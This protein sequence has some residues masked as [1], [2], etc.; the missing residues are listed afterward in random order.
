MTGQVVG[1]DVAKA[2]FD[3]STQKPDGKRKDLG[4]VPNTDAGIARAMRWIADYAP[5]ATVCMEATGVYHEP[6]AEALVGQGLTVYVVNPA[7]IS[8]YGQSELSR[9]KTDRTDAQLIMRFLLAQRAAAKPL[10]PWQPLPPAQKQLRAMVRRLDDVKQMRQMEANRLEV[11]DAT[12][13]A[14]I[15]RVL[16]TLDAQIQEIERRV[17]DHIDSDPDLRGRKDLLISIPG[18]AETTSA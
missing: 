11:A 2:S 4:K 15:Q 6:L 8:A 16:D 14:S 3:L 17:R 9:T 7:Q 10:T 5:G 18:I 13:H 1:I 12:V